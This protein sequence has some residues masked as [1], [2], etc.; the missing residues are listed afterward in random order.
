VE[1]LWQDVKYGIRMLRQKPAFTLVAVLTLALGIGANTAIFSVVNAILLRPL[2]FANSDRLVK[3][4]STNISRGLDQYG[5]A[6]PDFREWS[7]NTQALDQMAAHYSGE[8]N[9]LTGEEPEQI[10]GMFIS[11]SMFPMLG[12]DPAMGRNF[13]SEE[14]QFGRHRVVLL[15]DSLWQRRF[16][17]DPNLLG[18]A[19]TLD[20]QQ[21]VVVGIMSPDFRFFNFRGIELWTPMAFEADSPWNT[22]GNRFLDVVARLKPGVTVA[23][24][25]ADM[26]LIASRLE[27]EYKQNAGV[28]AKV[29]PL[30]QEIVG[31]FKLA[32]QVLLAAV[33]FVLLITCANVANLLLARA[34]GRRREIAI[35]ISLGAGRSRIIGMLLTES[36]LLGLLGGIIGV[37]LAVWWVDPLIA[38]GPAELRN[39]GIIN[40]DGRVLIFTLGITLLTST[41]FGIA[42]ALQLSKPD[43][44]ET[45]KEGTKGSTGGV[46]GRR[47]RS[48]LMVAEVALALVLLIGA[49]L[50]IKSFL[51][52]QKVNPGFN[53][54][55][56]LTM[57]ISLPASKYPATEPHKISGFYQ[58]ALNEIEQIPRVQSAGASSSIPLIGD[59]RIRKRFSIEGKKPPISLK[60]VPMVM[61]RQISPNFLRALGVPILK[62]Q[63]F[64]ERDNQDAPSVAIINET[65]AN[66]FFPNEDPIGKK[67]WMGPPE[68]LLPPGVLPP[69]FQFPRLTVIGVA[70]DLRQEGLHKPVDPEVYV[71]HS[72]GARR[73][74]VG[75][76]FVVVRTNSDPL[77]LASAVQSRI[78]AIDK[79]QPIANVVTMEK[80]LADSLS[81]PRFNMLLLGIFAAMA[82]VMAVAGI[83]GVISY[84]VSQR[85]HEIGIRMALGAQRSDVLRMVL[86]HGMALTMLG[87]GIGLALALAASRFLQKLLFEVQPT[88]PMTY[89]GVAALLAAVA[90]VACY[91]PARR[92]TKVDPMVALR[93]E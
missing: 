60:E 53:P 22:R 72:Q 24:A 36:L 81:Q 66:R 67:I 28:G 7:E 25:Q 51:R 14:E 59:G 42:P 74:T 17:A 1:T 8:F 34:A 38:L 6:P 47:I 16:N 27:Q 65:L 71:P 21:Y 9:L 45:L 85:T 31:R 4:W 76:M 54:E 87:V 58:Q 39:A 19:I 93:Y 52:L 61:Y 62:G 33:G 88:D 2:P 3:V 12:V 89:A 43:F 30:Q 41:V 15:S 70:G 79:D 20:G 63:P 91:I 68:D 11:P 5:T 64:T 13:T 75:T 26:E 46:R 32:L 78:L 29:V 84:S 40:V 69:N 83:Y 77:K 73:E 56:A 48:I 49:G 37:A 35:R 57:V 82:L 10:R 23:Q 18:Q 90:L 44:N 86:G 50:M 80:L 92:A 55:N